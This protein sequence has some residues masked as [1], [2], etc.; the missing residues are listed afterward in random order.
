[1]DIRIKA[2][3]QINNTR[4]YHNRGAAMI[5][6]VCVMAVVMILSLTLLMVAYQ[7]LATVNDEGRDELYYQQAMSFSEVLRKRLESFSS[8]GTSSDE[9]VN[10]IDSFMSNDAVGAPDTET[11]TADAPVEDGVYGAITLNLNKKIS[12]GNLVIT[13]SVSDGDKMMS[14]CICK[15]KYDN[16]GGNSQYT[17]MGYY[18]RWY[19]E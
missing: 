17:F 1:M 19:E 14:S 7:M 8:T 15:Y 4:K 3:N 9:L 16:N 6:V 10:H 13:I 18:D 2:N 11:L 5:V 12:Y